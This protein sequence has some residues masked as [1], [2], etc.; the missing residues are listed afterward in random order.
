MYGTSHDMQELWVPLLSLL[1]KKI[2]YDFKKKNSKCLIG[3]Q[4]MIKMKSK[5]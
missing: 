3:V 1:K 2:K 4:N 5:N